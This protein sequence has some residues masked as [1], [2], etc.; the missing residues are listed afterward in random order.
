MRPVGYRPV[1]IILKSQTTMPV[2]VQDYAVARAALDQE[3][4]S[5]GR[6]LTGAHMVT[7][8]GYSTAE[9]LYVAHYIGWTIADPQADAAVC[10]G[11]YQQY[12]GAGSHRAAI[13]TLRAHR[14]P[15]HAA[16]A[17]ARAVTDALTPDYPAYLNA[18]GRR[19]HAQRAALVALHMLGMPMESNAST[20]RAGAAVRAIFEPPA[21]ARTARAA[22]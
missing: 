4:E 22:C 6:M 11:G 13:A 1:T 5:Q 7:H 19:R 16:Q 10:A 2:S 9:A 21:T 3:A 8:R 12:A 17:T 15:L 20:A 18:A 14:M